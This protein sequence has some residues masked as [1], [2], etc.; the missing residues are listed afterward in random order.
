MATAAY[1]RRRRSRRETESPEAAL[2][3]IEAGFS[4]NDAAVIAAFAGA[5]VDPSA[6]DPRHNVLTFNA[7]K[8]KGRRVARGATSVRVTVWIPAGRESEG[9]PAANDAAGEVRADS[10]GE[11]KRLRPVVA[12]LFHESQTVAADAPAGARPAAWLNP[13]LVKAGAYDDAIAAA[14]VAGAE[15]T[16]RLFAD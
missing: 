11:R 9:E 14:A 12:R 1:S 2:A 15:V 5:G 13:A 10:K 8:A 6:I 16:G 3:R 7:W 4:A